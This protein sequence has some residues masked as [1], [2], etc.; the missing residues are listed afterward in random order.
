M[1][2]RRRH[3]L[4]RLPSLPPSPLPSLLPLSALLSLLAPLLLPVLLPLLALPSLLV[5][6]TVHADASEIPVSELH[7]PSI[8]VFDHTPPPEGTRTAPPGGEVVNPAEFC[9]ADAMLIHWASAHSQ[10]LVDMCLAIAESDRVICCARS[11]ADAAEAEAAMSAA[12]VHMANVEFLVTSGGSVWIRDYGPFS[13]YDDG[14]LSIT[15]M[16]YGPMGDIDD[17]PIEIADQY[18]LPWYRSSLIHQGGNH[19]TD[20]NGMGFSSTNLTSF[21]PAWEMGAIREE[22]QSYLGLDSLV[23]FPPMQ[24]DATQHCDMWMKLLTDTLFVVGEYEHPEDAVGDDAAYLDQLAQDLD[25]MQNLDG[26]DFEVVRL[27]MNPVVFEGFYSI[28]RTYTNSLIL[29]DKVLVPVYG[30]P[31]DAEALQLYAQLM[32]DHEIIGID[33]S[34]LIHYLGAIHCITNIVHH[35]NPV[36]ILHEPLVRVDPG[37][38]PVLSCRLNPRFGD[39]E[40]ELHYRSAVSGDEGVIPAVFSGGVWRAQ[41]PHVFEDFG[42]WF[43]ARVLTEAGV[44]ETSLPEGAPDEVFTCLVREVSSVEPGVLDPVLDPLTFDP[45]TL[46]SWPKPFT[47]ETTI[48]FSLVRDE[49][50]ELGVYDSG[51]RLTRRLLPERLMVAGHHEVAWDGR[52]DGGELLPSGVYLVRAQ[53]GRSVGFE[54]LVLIR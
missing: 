39:R 8:D 45:E 50:V 24:G 19:L 54:R 26:R 11:S 53:A 43:E 18:E 40:V 32:P 44:L 1:H 12:G 38:E 15:D 7:L 28:N 52:D 25:E 17:I 47:G 5:A 33:S 42:Y 41:M 22:M 31:L 14:E 4:L 10:V 3:S 46:T 35:S 27:P 51:G 30:T 2:I 34:N 21:N 29:N 48:G 49:L 20:G 36:V 9:R 13:I 37:A 23:I 16:R 6:G